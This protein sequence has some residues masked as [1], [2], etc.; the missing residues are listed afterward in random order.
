M[1]INYTEITATKKFL[2]NTCN[3]ASNN[4]NADQKKKKKNQKRFKA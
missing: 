1:L 3:S 4:M 2:E